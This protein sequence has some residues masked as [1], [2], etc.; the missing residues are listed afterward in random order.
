M[1]ITIQEDEKTLTVNFNG[2]LD[3]LSSPEAGKE[4]MPLIN[5]K[6]YETIIL[7]CH[8]LAYI[9]SSGL[10]L[11][12]TIL[13]TGK[14]KGGRVILKDVNDAVRTILDTTGFVTLFEFQ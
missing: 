2:R 13:K 12:F 7:D 9:A 3:S 10:R 5:Q 1:D 14:M 8:E 11:I 4:I 6:D